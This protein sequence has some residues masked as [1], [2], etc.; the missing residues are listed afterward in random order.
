[1]IIPDLL[2]LVWDDQSLVKAPRQN[3][4]QSLV[5][6]YANLGVRVGMFLVSRI[7]GSDGAE[8]NLG[9]ITQRAWE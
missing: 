5:L 8:R 2:V 3:L 9:N 7:V 1:M 4:V 6:S